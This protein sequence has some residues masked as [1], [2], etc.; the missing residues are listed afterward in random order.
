MKKMKQVVLYLL[1]AAIF[2]P[3][4]LFAQA[5]FKQFY[6][7]GKGLS[8]V[9]N[10]VGFY[11]V[12]ER[13]TNYIGIQTNQS[14]AQISTTDLGEIGVKIIQN[15]DGGF[16]KLL[17]TDTLV[18]LGGDGDVLWSNFNQSYQNEKT[19]DF[20][21]LNDGGIALLSLVDT[22][23]YDTSSSQSYE[24]KALN[25]QK[26]SGSGQEEWSAFMTNTFDSLGV[27]AITID[28]EARIAQCNNGR[29]V[30]IASGR[31]VADSVR[32]RQ[33]FRLEESGSLAS[34]KTEYM[35]IFSTETLD[36]IPLDSGILAVNLNISGQVGLSQYANYTY[37]KLGA[38]TV[39]DSGFSN[40]G[41]VQKKVEYFSAISALDGGVLICADAVDYTGL[42]GALPIRDHTLRRL[43]ASGS[44]VWKRKVP[45]HAYGGL[46]LENNFF[47]LTGEQGGLIYLMTVPDTL[48]G[49]LLISMACPTEYPNQDSMQLDVTFKNIGGATIA[50]EKQ[51]FIKSV[52][53]EQ[54]IGSILGEFDVPK[55]EPNDSVTMSI[56]VPGWL[57]NLPGHYPNYIDIHG[58]SYVRGYYIAKK[59]PTVPHFEYEK[60]FD[61]YCKKFSTDLSIKTVVQDSS[62][63]DGSGSFELQVTNNGG[64]KAY[65]IKVEVR[66]IGNS[67]IPVLVDSIDY[68]AGY[69]YMV[70]IINHLDVGETHIA[71]ANFKTTLDTV[72]FSVKASSGHNIDVDTLNNHEHITF[73]NTLVGSSSVE[74]GTLV[75]LYPNPV[76]GFLHLSLSLMEAKVLFFTIYDARGQRLLSEKKYLPQGVSEVDFDVSELPAGM[77]FVKAEGMNAYH[78]FVIMR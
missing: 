59:R 11:L 34:V 49:E 55:L 62:L 41:D 45:S 40:F 58:W 26:I 22:L 78:N 73:Y 16:T 17:S 42:D 43:D 31:V 52:I 24:Y 50:P 4:L 9:K 6:G 20:C 33:V 38:W 72:S 54:C 47:A 27:L 35:S 8:V 71:K 60:E 70:Y 37:N 36:V 39:S 23:V 64:Q 29:I 77:Y 61:Y 3:T 46:D 74:G 21:A 10:D 15:K 19:I 28:G 68:A 32:S 30:V 5:P 76:N 66:N 69:K 1:C 44:T 75:S 65:N 18:K 25:I 57:L 67:F 7:S 48:E 13:D 12:A 14:G 2:G 51:Y 56:V 53:C 63:V